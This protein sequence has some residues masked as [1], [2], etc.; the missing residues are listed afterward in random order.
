MWPFL[1][2][3]LLHLVR[4]VDESYKFLIYISDYKL[5]KLNYE[6]DQLYPHLLREGNMNYDYCIK[7]YLVFFGI[8]ISNINFNNS[9]CNF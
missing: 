5:C 7:C 6:C 9:K 3:I 4:S 8:V 1:T 2:M